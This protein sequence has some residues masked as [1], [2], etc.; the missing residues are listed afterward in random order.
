VTRQQRRGAPLPGRKGR[1]AP[2]PPRWGG[3]PDP[4]GWLL[5]ALMV[6]AAVL[7]YLARGASAT[8]DPPGQ[9][10]PR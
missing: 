4:D 3:D 8:L 2:G 6:A 1:Y 5:W 10:G 9:Q 7:A